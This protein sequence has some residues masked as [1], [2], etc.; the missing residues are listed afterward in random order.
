MDAEPTDPISSV[1]AATYDLVGETLKGIA[2]GPMEAYR[3]IKSND[4]GK[5]PAHVR[6]HSRSVSST[7]EISPSVVDNNTSTRSSRVIHESPVPEI[8][9]S[10]IS[11]V[12]YDP[13]LVDGNHEQQ[14]GLLPEPEPSRRR[15]RGLQRGSMATNIVEPIGKV[16]VATSKGIVRIVGAGVKSPMTFTYGLT[17]GFHNMPKMY[18][19][20]T[21]RDVETVTDVKSGLS[22]AGKVRDSLISSYLDDSL[23][24]L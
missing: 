17:R 15:R 9:K 13:S 6:M 20:K 22:A 4:K 2:E 8:E 10:I 18:G 7:S 3:Q 1:T 12:D 19:D 16:A 23:H 24:L 11:D 14:S 21:V 5:R